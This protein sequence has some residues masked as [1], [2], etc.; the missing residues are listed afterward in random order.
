VIFS[1]ELGE[2]GGAS[3]ARDDR[4]HEL[5]DFV[6]KGCTPSMAR[7]E[8][9]ENEVAQAT[10]PAGVELASGGRVIRSSLWIEE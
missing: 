9:P 3:E 5:P 2:A 10:V 7:G 8:A 1:A 6:C 4:K